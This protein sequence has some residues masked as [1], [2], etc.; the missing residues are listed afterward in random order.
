MSESDSLYAEVTAAL[1]RQDYR[2]AS[3]LLKRWQTQQPQD[4]WLRLAVAQ[5]QEATGKREAAAERYRSLLKSTTIAK[6]ITQARQGLA[7]LDQL[8]TDRRQTAIAQATADPAGQSLGV[9]VL[10]PVTGGDRKSRAQGLAKVLKIDP[11]TAQ[12]QLPSR[13][14]RCHRTGAIGELQFYQQE[15]AQVRVPA[16]CHSL[17]ALQAI[18]VFQVSHVQQLGEQITVVCYNAANQLGALQFNTTEVSQ[19]VIGLVPI[20]EEVIDVDPW[21]KLQR[22]QKTQDYA[23]LM[24]V[25]LR[26]RQAI[27]RFCDRTYQFPDGVQFPPFPQEPTQVGKPTLQ[28]NWNRLKHALDSQIHSPVHDSFQTF[29]QSA[30]E[31]VELF[32]SK[33]ESHVTLYRKIATEWDQVFHLYSTLAFLHQPPLRPDRSD[34]A[35][36]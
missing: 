30:L 12:M 21:K 28:V 33:F 31:F 9:L 27:L 34:R 10:E 22:K 14:W 1:G 29:G 8:E 16:F 6:I 25:H 7:R 18:H 35:N 13:G 2:V 4:L 15:L 36:S 19:R 11:Y 3:I 26:E 24:D 20:L 17:D 32:G 5:F 23:N